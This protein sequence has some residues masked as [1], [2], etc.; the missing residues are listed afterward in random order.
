MG[1]PMKSLSNAIVVAVLLAAGA[2]LP[3]QGIA[4]GTEA[5]QVAATDP[6]AL[7]E[8]VRAMHAAIL[9]AA[10]SG[11]IEAMR[12]VL[13]SNELMPQVSFGGA[14]D[15]I[16]FWKEVSGDYEGREILAVLVNILQMPYARARTGTPD[17]MYVWPYLAEADLEKLTP[18]QE[19]DLYRL[20]KPL[21]AK[22]MRE[23]GGYIGYR[24]GIGADGTW[25]YFLAGD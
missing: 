12:P 25:H 10:R 11:D 22:A 23:F 15:P 16:A 4:R 7:P 21:E 18:P 2:V 19:V 6:E 9:E 24:L 17:E 13:E 1:K 8:R 5:P 14:D 20:V 3:P